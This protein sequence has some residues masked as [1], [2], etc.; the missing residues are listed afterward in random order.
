[1]LVGI[2]LFETLHTRQFAPADSAEEN[3][4]SYTTEVNQAAADMG[5]R[6]CGEFVQT[7]GGIYN[8]RLTLW[9]SAEDDTLIVVSGGTV[10]NIPQR[11]T[12]LFSHVGDGRFLRT[13]DEPGVA[14]IS[15]STEL[16]V[17]LHGNLRELY[18]SHRSRLASMSLEPLKFDTSKI[19]CEYENIKEIQV[20]RMRDLG[21]VR[22]LN[23][24]R[25][26]Y[27]H[28]LKGAIANYK[29][30]FLKQLAISLSQKSRLNVKRPGT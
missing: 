14:D 11:R 26:I 27:R 19:L 6:N 22:Y 30:G 9:M 24:E 28:T 13:I 23:P 20:E 16:N 7:R 25:T 3:K 10:A 17:L 29:E 4:S 15:G 12:S 21:L 5:L 8:A 2:A 1:M 18:E